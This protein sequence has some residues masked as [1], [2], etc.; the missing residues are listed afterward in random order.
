MRCIARNLPLA[1]SLSSCRSAHISSSRGS[2]D[3]AGSA[4][5]AAEITASEPG[6]TLVEVRFH[7][8]NSV[9]ISSS[10]ILK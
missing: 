3:R 1:S 2:K 5:Q 9:R 6:I 8:Y 4:S 7:V 10:F